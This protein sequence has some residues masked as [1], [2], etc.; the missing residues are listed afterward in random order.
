MHNGKKT[1]NNL[2]EQ[3]PFSRGLLKLTTQIRD[4]GWNIQRWKWK[5][6]SLTMPAMF[7][8]GPFITCPEKTSSGS[9]MH[10]WSK[11]LDSTQRQEISSKD[12]CS[13]ALERKLGC[14]SSN[15]NREWASQKKLET[16]YINI[17]K[18]IQLFQRT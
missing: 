5:T 2:Q 1:P 8:R 14:P 12:G 15:F 6:N 7:G 17:C 18:L 4:F 16:C 10:I 11:S 13:G 9:N 3:D